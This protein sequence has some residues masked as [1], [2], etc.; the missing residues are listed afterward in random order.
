MKWQI[1]PL[2]C[3]IEMNLIDPLESHWIICSL[4]IRTISDIICIFP[5]LP[6]PLNIFHN[7]SK[8][9]ISGMRNT[10]MRTHLILTAFTL[11]K[12][13][14]FIRF[15]P[16]QSDH[17]VMTVRERERARETGNTLSTESADIVNCMNEDCVIPSFDWW[18]L[19]QGVDRLHVQKMQKTV[20]N[21][22][23][24]HSRHLKP[25][26]W[27]R[28]SCS[29]CIFIKST[30]SSLC[31]NLFPGCSFCLSA[32]LSDTMELHFFSHCLT[33]MSIWSSSVKQILNLL[34]IWDPSMLE[35]VSRVCY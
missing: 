33:K 18:R 24:S 22:S 15:Q 17:P 9:P 35:N 11:L 27:S 12:L 26:L 19:V 16:V 10:K 4:C 1:A 3:P 31:H 34:T 25:E 23:C 7:Y 30:R 14:P 5:D 28:L 8:F 2:K 13:P 6:H 21:R 32:S 29:T 20:P